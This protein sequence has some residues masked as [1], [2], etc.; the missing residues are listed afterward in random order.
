[1]TRVRTDLSL[2]EGH[3]LHQ[4]TLGDTEQ[5]LRLLAVLRN[6]RLMQALRTDTG[7]IFTLPPFL[8]VDH[9]R[10][11]RRFDE[12]KG[13]DRVVSIELDRAGGEF[14]ERLWEGVVAGSVRADPPWLPLAD[15]VHRL[16]R[17][18]RAALGWFLQDG[19]YGLVVLPDDNNALPTI[20][21]VQIQAGRAVRLVGR[22]GLDLDT[23]DPGPQDLLAG[24]EQC[25]GHPRLLL[26]GTHKALRRVFADP[27]PATLLERASIRGEIEIHRISTRLSVGLFLSRVLGL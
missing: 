14:L 13:V 4:L 12:A 11:V 21:C 27:H 26:S 10:E 1:M 16:P 23:C 22:A 15:L 9:P 25:V 19:A 6:G 3:A 24:I 17:S 7:P 18:V 5:E 8:V 2:E 20:I